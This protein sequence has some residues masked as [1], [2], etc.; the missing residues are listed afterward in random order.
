MTIL[1]LEDKIKSMDRNPYVNNYKEVVQMNTKKVSL[2]RLVVKGLVSASAK[3]AERN[4]NSACAWWL[5]QP[6]V[7]KEVKKLRKF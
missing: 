6:K 4:I 7:P 3:E 5:G 2:K 1:G